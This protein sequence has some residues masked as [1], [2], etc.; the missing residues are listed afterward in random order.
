[1][2]DKELLPC[3]FC[4]YNPKHEST[5]NEEVIYCELCPAKMVYDGSYEALKAAWNNRAIKNPC[6]EM[7]IM[8]TTVRNY[9]KKR[10]A[11]I[12]YWIKAGPG[13]LGWKCSTPEVKA[14]YLK[15]QNWLKKQLRE[16]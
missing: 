7:G 14:E 6:G 11:E 9:L 8:D 2:K 3:P 16:K 12:E 10:L 4:G 13:G 15:I 1:M 5:V